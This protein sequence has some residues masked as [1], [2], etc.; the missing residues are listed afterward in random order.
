L[1]M[2]IVEAQAA[3]M[4]VLTSHGV[5]RE[6]MVIEENVD[7][8]ALEDGVSH[9]AKESLR[10]LNLPRPNAANANLAISRSAFSI[11]NSAR[12]LLDIYS[13]GRLEGN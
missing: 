5:P 2:V 8:R 4:R 10:L 3:G 9:W 12:A 6:S 13:G 1:G 11:E 7:F